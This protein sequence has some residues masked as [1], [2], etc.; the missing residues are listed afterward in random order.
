MDG[1]CLSARSSSTRIAVARDMASPR[2]AS[3]RRNS[4]GVRRT[5]VGWARRISWRWGLA[6]CS[7][8]CYGQQALRSSATHRLQG[9]LS[10]HSAAPITTCSNFYSST[11]RRQ[12]LCRL[13]QTAAVRPFGDVTMAA[14]TFTHGAMA[15]QFDCA[16]TNSPR[17]RSRSPVTSSSSR[18][19]TCS[20]GRKALRRF[21]H[22]M[23]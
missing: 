8:R 13:L 22:S 2:Q 19:L 4:S 6:D 14:D 7:R 21:T 12:R 3:S 5:G 1:H 20:Q 16:Q 9:G 11:S 17:L 23:N 18:M 15:N 10:V